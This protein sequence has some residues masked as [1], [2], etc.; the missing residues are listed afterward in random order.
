MKQAIS[1]V[2]ETSLIIIIQADLNPFFSLISLFVVFPLIWLEYYLK[3]M[4]NKK[5]IELVRQILHV[6]TCFLRYPQFLLRE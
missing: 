5:E 4:I 2:K 6:V 1:P 3:I